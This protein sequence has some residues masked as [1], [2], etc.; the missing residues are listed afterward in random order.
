VLRL[1]NTGPRV[2]V[3]DFGSN[4]NKKDKASDK[5]YINIKKY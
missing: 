5:K 4:K 3:K 2:E 1:T